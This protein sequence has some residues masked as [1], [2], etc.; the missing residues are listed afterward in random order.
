MPASFRSHLTSLGYNGF[1]AYPSFSH[2]ALEAC[3]QDR[4]EKLSNTIDS[5]N[6]FEEK[7]DFF[8]TSV[9]SE[10]INLQFDGE[11]RVLFSEKLLNHAKIKNNILFV[12]M[13]KT[14]QIWEPKTF[15]KFKVVAKK[16][17]Y[18]N[19]SSLKW[20]NNLTGE[21]K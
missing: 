16:K 19:R 6:P 8:A 2:E 13:G 18:Q 4:I 11:G 20:D 9:L 7:R 14:F 21:K 3:S 5:L 10:S 1:I 15:D 12:G 17:A